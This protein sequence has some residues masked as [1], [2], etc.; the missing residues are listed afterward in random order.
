M[1]LVTYTFRGSSRL[2]AMAGDGE[3]IDLNRAYALHLR[4]R[5]EPRARER[6]DAI[7]PPDMLSFLEG[8]DEAMEAARTALQWG[9]AF[10]KA[11]MEDAI[12]LGVQFSA[13]E[14][15]FHLEAPVTNPR[16]VLA[17]GLNYRE[18]AAEG[19][20][21]PPAYPIVFSKGPVCIVGP[22]APVVKPAESDRVDWEGELCVVIGRAGRRVPRASALDYV[23]GFMN[24]ND[25]SV[26]D[27]QRHNPQWTMGKNWDT[28]G[29][30]G[31]YLVTRDEVDCANLD[32]STWVNGELMQRANTSDLIFPVDVLIEYISTASTLHPGDVIFTGTPSGVGQARTPPRFLQAGDVVRVEISGLGVLENPVVAED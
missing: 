26:R 17:I 5:G 16:N 8:G 4:G 3:V 20:R 13:S 30:T 21:E 25:V 7:V 9:M 27:W 15:G 32:L 24:G 29:P 6:A 22:G 2:G 10:A 18:H 12:R 23:A 28:H 14:A 31:P 11:N 1:R 19:G